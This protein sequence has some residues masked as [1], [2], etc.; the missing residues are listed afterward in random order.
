MVSC[1]KVQRNKSEPNYTCC[2]H[3]E[4]NVF[5]LIK[6]FGNFTC[7]HRINRAN[8]DKHDWEEERNHVGRID[9]RVAHEKIILSSWIM[10]LG[11]RWSDDHPHYIDD[12]LSIKRRLITVRLS[13]L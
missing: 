6:R 4:S 13:R 2:V 3:G 11:M 10:I 9:V 12:N 5:R 1:C 7:Q 8:N